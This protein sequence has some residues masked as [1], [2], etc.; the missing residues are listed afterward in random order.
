MINLQCLCCK[1]AQFCL[2]ADAKERTERVFILSENDFKRYDC[3]KYF[4]DIFPPSVFPPSESLF[5]KDKEEQVYV[6]LMLV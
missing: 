4:H 3:F 2:L 6:K 1:S 5:S